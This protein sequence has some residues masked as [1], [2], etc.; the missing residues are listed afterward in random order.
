MMKRYA[1][2]QGVALHTV[3]SVQGREMDIVILLTTRTNIDFDESEFFDDKRRMNVA[4]TRCRHGQFVLGR[5]SALEKLPYW[6][7]LLQWAN[8]RGV[9]VST[10]TLPDLFD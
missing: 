9:V 10:S 3:D 1:A 2:L 5:V 6:R 8:D 4:V 7:R